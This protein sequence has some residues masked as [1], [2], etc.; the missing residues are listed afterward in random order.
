MSALALQQTDGVMLR[1]ENHAKRRYYQA[2]LQTNL[3][4]EWEVARSWGGIGSRGGR[5]C[6]DP[7]GNSEDGKT[8]IFGL[9]ARRLKRG[10]SLTVG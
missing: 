3:F 2:R 9:D 1:W 7:V 6:F 8:A 10:Y 4:G 5:V